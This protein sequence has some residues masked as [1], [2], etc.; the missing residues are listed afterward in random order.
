MRNTNFVVKKA[1]FF[2]ISFLF[3]AFTSFVSARTKTLHY[4]DVWAELGENSLL[5]G[6]NTE[7]PNS[8]GVGGAVGASYE[9]QHGHLLFQAGLGIAPL[10]TVFK[11]ETNDVTL[12]DQT[13]YEGEAFNYVYGI[14]DRKDSY[15]NMNLQVPIMIGAQVNRFYFLVGAKVGILMNL[16]AK[17]SAS[18]TTTGVYDNY[19][20][21]FHDMPEYYFVND[22]SL[23]TS[24]TTNFG[25]D[26]AL[27]GEIG[28][29][30]G[31]LGGE[32]GF[33]R[34]RRT[35]RYRLGLFADYGLTNVY[36]SSNVEPLVTP[37][38]YLT[39]GN[40][41]DML[42]GVAMRDIASSNRVD[43]LNNLFVGVRFTV[44][45]QLPEPRH[46]VMCDTDR[47]FSPRYSQT[48][49]RTYNQQ[50]RE[51]QKQPRQ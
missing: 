13:D 49:G 32:T 40:I 27:S 45:F 25:L 20:G 9:L 47:R 22:Q 15:L 35:T 34:D 12:Y 36:K 38:S 17:S 4:I 1:R 23:S 44:L 51:H 24:R 26:L 10:Y 41:N 48:G 7:V 2:A 3:L 42:N 28:L 37:S 50:L 33:N 31:N 16:Q 21:T 14:S 39:N 11:P 30:L 43:K 8:L 46:C 19:A 6:G 18:V 5:T 29:R